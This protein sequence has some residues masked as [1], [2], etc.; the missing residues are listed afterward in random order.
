MRVGADTV[1]SGLSTGARKTLGVFSIL[2][3][4]LLLYSASLRQNLSI[5]AIIPALFTLAIAMACFTKG[6]SQKF[7]GSLIAL[8]I[9]IIS[10]S[11]IYSCLIDGPVVS[12]SRSK[13]SLV[14]SLCAFAL[15]G[16]PSAIYL[17]KAKFGL[18]SNTKI[19]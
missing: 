15:F 4:L 11:C 8:A 16:A 7:Y 3:S 6:K 18:S 2:F 9:L 19:D 10:F 5:L 1:L 12:E 14:N 13:P 17:Y